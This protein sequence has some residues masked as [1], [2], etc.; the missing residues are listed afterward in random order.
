MFEFKYR[1]KKN[2]ETALNQAKF[3]YH[4]NILPFRGKIFANGV[5][6]KNYNCSP[7]N[8]Y[9]SAFITQCRSVFQYAL[10]EIKQA[11]YQDKKQ[12]LYEKYINEHPLIKLFKDLRDT[13]IHVASIRNFV[14]I[15]LQVKLNGSRKPDKK[16]EPKRVQESEIEYKILKAIIPDN[17]I[18]E[19]LKS[20]KKL[21][22][23]EAIENGEQLYVNITFD[24]DSDLFSLCKKYLLEIEQFISYCSE[25]MLIS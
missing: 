22:L 5:I 7:L 15:N 10:K 8:I 13:D 11:D 21:D 23:V 2:I 25:N 20:E 1:S 18:Y 17:D 24:D 3:L 14:T 6:D 16:I 9:F 19:T 4:N 12:R